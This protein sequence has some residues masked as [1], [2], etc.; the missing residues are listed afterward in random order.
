MRKVYN[1]N[2]FD[3]LQTIRKDKI[4]RK[5]KKE[6]IMAKQTR[7]P[8]DCRCTETKNVNTGKTRNNKKEMTDCKNSK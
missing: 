4:R 6:N 1:P 3:I 7:K 5:P 2:L 8:E